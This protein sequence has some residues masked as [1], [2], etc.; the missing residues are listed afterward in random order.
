MD[1]Q[2]WDDD[3]SHSPAH[4]PHQTGK[5]R[6]AKRKKLLLIAGGIGAALVLAAGAFWFVAMRGSSTQNPSRKTAAPQQTVQ[7]LPT[8]P[9]DS[10]PV[11][12]KSTKLNIEFTYRKDWTFKEIASSGEVTLTSPRTSYTKADG[13]AATGVFTLK[14]RKGATDVIKAVIEK[15]VAARDS[16]VIAYAAPTEQQ[17]YYTNVS[18]AGSKKDVFNF[19]IVT[20]S[21]ELKAGNSFAYTLALD[22]DSF[23]IA[24]GYGA[25]PT[26]SFS[27]D[28]VPATAIT[29]EPQTQAIHIVESIKI[30]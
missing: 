23:V 4:T 1:N 24:G 16:E 8:T 29:S 25:D 9:A 12:Y 14:I 22:N 5:L 18:Y 13:Q 2:D 27:F 10:T 26:N 17:R 3:N 11:T 20:G 28:P 30:Y 7:P 15:S 19:F 6:A 21:V